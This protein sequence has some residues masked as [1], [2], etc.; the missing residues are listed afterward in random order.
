MRRADLGAEHLLPLARRIPLRIDATNR[1]VRLEHRVRVHAGTGAETLDH[2]A[3]LV[4]VDAVDRRSS[5]TPASGR[6]GSASS[7][8]ATA[9]GPTSSRTRRTGMSGETV[10]AIGGVVAELT[11]CVL[12]DHPLRRTSVALELRLD[13]VDGFAIPLGALTPVAELSEAAK[14]L[15]VFLELQ[16]LHEQADGVCRQR[17]EI[18][19][20]RCSRGGCGGT[21]GGRAVLGCG[22]NGE[23]GE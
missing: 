10:D 9:G 6:A 15:L 8:S 5:S 17:V 23:N 3:I 16:P 13:P 11:S 18:R 2:V 20:A 19:S 21:L 7:R 4:V 14:G 22:R 12:V 1:G